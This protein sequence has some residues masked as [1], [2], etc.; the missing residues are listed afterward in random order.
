MHYW[1]FGILFIFTAF[2][3][4]ADLV[5]PGDECYDE[6]C[7]VTIHEQEGTT[8]DVCAA[9]PGGP[10]TGPE[11]DGGFNPEHCDFKF[12][13]TDYVKVCQTRG[14]S[15]WSEVW[16]DGPPAENYPEANDDCN[17]DDDADGDEAGTTESSP[18]GCSS[19]DSVASGSFFFLLGG[20]LY[21][22]RRRSR[23]KT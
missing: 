17:S 8:C 5:G 2:S 12:Q 9:G 15:F 21:A 11:W 22:R 14:E 20:I 6:I 4:K 10:S 16:C 19:I 18:F 3:A 7:T 13:G 23:I 1:L